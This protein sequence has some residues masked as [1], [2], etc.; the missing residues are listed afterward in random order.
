MTS[1][2]PAACDNGIKHKEK[3]GVIVAHRYGLHGCRCNPQ[4]QAVADERCYLC[5][6]NPFYEVL[7]RNSNKHNNTMMVTDD[8]AADEDLDMYVRITPHR[9]HGRVVDVGSCLLLKASAISEILP[10]FRLEVR[11]PQSFC[12]MMLS[13]GSLTPRHLDIQDQPNVHGSGGGQ[14]GMNARQV[15]FNF[16]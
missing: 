1:I 15:P 4:G 6:H 13:F 12:F 9:A 3:L 8:E 7:F 2:S 5:P 14:R 11:P 16:V 10:S